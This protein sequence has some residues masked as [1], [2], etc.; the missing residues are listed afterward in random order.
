MV[1]N[2]C[3]NDLTPDSGQEIRNAQTLTQFF[4]GTPVSLHRVE[5]HPG[6]T[7]LIVTVEGTDPFAEPLTLLG[8]T[9]VVPADRSAWSHDPF[10]AEISDGQIWGR[11]TVDMLGLTAAMAAVT[12]QVARAGRPRGTLTFAAV[13]DEEARGGLGAGWLA[14]NEPDLFSWGNCISE[15]GGSHLHAIDGSDAVVVAVGEKGAAQRRLTVRSEPGH[16]STPWG[17]V[18]AV[19][20]I[21]EVSARLSRLALPASHD[22]LWHGFVEAFGFDAATEHAL[23][24][25]AGDDVYKAFGPLARY[26]HAI[27]H[28]TVAQTV[29]GGG[30]A[31]NVIPGSAF[32][33][34]DIRTLP[35]QSDDDVDAV[36]RAG[37]AEMA[38]EVR[39]E[40]L[41]SEPATASSTDT[42]L[43]RI[44]EA[45]IGEFL[46]G[47]PV[48]PTIGSGG[49]D[50]RFARHLGGVGYGFSLY[51]RDRT[52][53]EVQGLWHGTDEHIAVDDLDLTVQALQRVVT[54]FIDA[55]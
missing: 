39:I 14:A 38:G 20:K 24:A 11:G 32:L 5:P 7:T 55:G 13:A 22:P 26:A 2:G 42:E 43:Y 28:L 4:D 50:L 35:G 9:D 27:S 45:T 36:L 17:R 19:Q 49:T 1:R 37:L 8:H 46:P 53:G 15:F 16:G 47:V 34:L 18:S 21:A 48:V 10:G 31:I 23:L 52:L 25:G 29:V 12:R 6:R 51:H 33:E 44:I 54:R 30:K 3:E 41:I 40:R